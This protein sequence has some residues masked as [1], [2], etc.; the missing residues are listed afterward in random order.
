MEIR[1]NGK[2]L[3]VELEAE[4][5]LGEIM[6]GL[7]RWV[8]E[9]GKVV[10]H[11]ILN[12]QTLLAADQEAASIPLEDIKTLELEIIEKE[13]L[14]EEDEALFMKAE[15]LDATTILENMMEMKT[16]IPDLAA[17][18]E[19]VSIGLTTGGQA[20]AMD[21]LQ[22]VTRSIDEMISLLK[23]TRR[24]FDLEYQG[25]QIGE[26][27]IEDKIMNLKSLL[28]EIITAFEHNDLVMLSD[29]LEYE[30]APMLSS[31]GEVMDVLIT[32]IE[33]RVN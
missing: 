29:L 7:T 30:L 17:Q 1:V 26:Q 9:Q 10:L 2:P 16:R 5:T 18:L 11:V 28:A 13:A 8:I 19:G 20:Q 32:E 31:W 33:K 22:G 23:D 15:T 21:L 6:D 12:G 27:S 24:L 14:S 3:E 25:I 4:K